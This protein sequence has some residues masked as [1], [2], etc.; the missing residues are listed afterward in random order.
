MKPFISMNLKTA[1]QP[2]GLSNN[3]SSFIIPKDHICALDDKTPQE[4]YYE[5]AS[6]PGHDPAV[7]TIKAAA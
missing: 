4:A 1:L 6:Q 3:G 2:K 5:T 7:K